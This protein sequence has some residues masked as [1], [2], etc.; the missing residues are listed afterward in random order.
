MIPVLGV[1]AA[2]VAGLE[3]LDLLDVEKA[4]HGGGVIDDSI[5]YVEVFIARYDLRRPAFASTSREELYATALAQAAYCDSNGFDALV[6]SEHHGVDDGY[7]PSPLVMAAAFAAVT[8]SIRITIAALLV[9]LHDP[10]RLAEDIAVLDH[11]SRGRASFVFGLGYRE[12][13][14]AMFDRPWKGRGRHMED[15]IG[16]MLRAWTG[17]PFE[18]EGR[19]VRV[20]PAPYSTP[21]PMVFYGG[22]P[23]RAARRA[24][25]LGLDFFPQTND[26]ALAELYR[27]GVPGERPGAGVRAAAQHRAR[28]HLPGNLDHF[29]GSRALPPI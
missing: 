15:A 7:L 12:E 9:P 27:S 17:E 11:V 25:R 1:E 20:T 29:L 21:R 16:T 5:L 18:Y 24:A 6:L 8:S 26:P 22:V 2:E 13:E 4:L 23:R 19:T 3:L 14:Y 28:H 10:L